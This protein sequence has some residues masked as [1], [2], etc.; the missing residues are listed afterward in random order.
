MVFVWVG[1]GTV[2]AM[3]AAGL[4]WR[5][6]WKPRRVN[7]PASIVE[8]LNGFAVEFQKAGDSM[9]TLAKKFDQGGRK[10]WKKK[11]DMILKNLQRMNR[12]LRQLNQFF[13]EHSEKINGELR[14]QKDSPAKGD[15][16]SKGELEKFKKMGSISEKELEDLDWEEIFRKLGSD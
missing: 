11:S 15:F 9:A 3:I 5:F 7:L 4:I 16:E 14:S 2:G 12:L 13:E 8:E 6:I 1:L 10:L